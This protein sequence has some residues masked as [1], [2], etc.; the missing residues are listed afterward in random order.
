MIQTVAYVSANPARRAAR[1]RHRIVDVVE[2]LDH[3]AHLV[4]QIDE[5][6]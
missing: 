5:W 6:T 2:P 1:S 3:R 4:Q